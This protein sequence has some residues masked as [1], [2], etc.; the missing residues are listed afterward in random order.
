MHALCPSGSIV[1]LV[2]SL[3]FA[4]CAQTRLQPGVHIVAAADR[5]KDLL[6]VAGEYLCTR[7]TNV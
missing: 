1:R 7:C 3:V 5:D 6:E 4:L 2:V